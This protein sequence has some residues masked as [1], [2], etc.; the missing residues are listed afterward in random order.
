MDHL[1]WCWTHALCASQWMRWW[2]CSQPAARRH[3]C[4]VDAAR[5]WTA[6][7]QRHRGSPPYHD[8]QQSALSLRM[9]HTQSEKDPA[10]GRKVRH[11]NWVWQLPKVLFETNNITTS[12]Q[13]SCLGIDNIRNPFRPPTK[14][15]TMQSDYAD[16]GSVIG[17][18][19]YIMPI[20][21]FSQLVLHCNC[22]HF[23]YQFK[24]I[25]DACHIA[26]YRTIWAKR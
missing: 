18:P 14:M 7:W 4:C 3:R 13:G 9:C 1:T 22:Y 25:K 2:S 21:C 15:V 5:S 19:N 20:C 8:D 6:N 17:L 26:L 11:I 23:D 24:V 16:Q 12:L 10:G